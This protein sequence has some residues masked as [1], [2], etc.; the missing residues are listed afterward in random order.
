MLD[1][2]T[3]APRSYVS[4]QDSLRHGRKALSELK[5]V[6][7][8]SEEERKSTAS[9]ITYESLKKRL[10]HRASSSIRHVHSVL[11]GSLSDS[12]RSSL[13]WK[14]SWV[15]GKSLGL[16]IR[17]ENESFVEQQHSKLSKDELELWN[18]IIDESQLLPK[19]DPRT[20]YEFLALRKRP[21]CTS[22]HRTTCKNCGFSV[23]HSQASAGDPAWYTSA[24][25]KIP[26]D[27][28]RNTPLHYSAASGT[29]SLYTFTN[30][31]PHDVD[32]HARNTMNESFLHLLDTGYSGKQG[33]GGSPAYLGLL[34][35]LKSRRFSF[36]D[37]DCHG[38]TILHVLLKR[39][40][41]ADAI[42][43]PHDVR[44][45]L[46]DLLDILE[47]LKPDLNALD[48]QGCNIGDE[49]ITWC[50]RLPST[51][52]LQ[53]HSRVVSL[54]NRYRNPLNANISFRLQI[55]PA[56]WKSEDWLKGLEMANTV[57]WIDIHGDTPLIAILKEWK[58]RNKELELQEMVRRLVGLGVDINMRD[59]CGNT[60][61]A[62][63]AIRGLRAC[64]AELLILGVMPNSRDYRGNSI[65]TV[66]HSRMHQASKAKKNEHYSRILSCVTLLT[67]FGAKKNP[68]QYEEWL[69][70]AFQRLKSL[71]E[72]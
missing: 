55:S 67:D 27:I 41:L 26:T 68:T 69:P 2:S 28:F 32:I 36:S 51:I 40:M 23:L 6:P 56:N 20:A 17:S 71:P 13:S 3:L 15:S 5:P 12:Y 25:D 22:Q 18:D 72:L 52:E 8:R 46:E 70:S 9:V 19:R 66:A 58:Q 45:I 42:I 37:R 10:S 54:V 63:A 48:N 62:I 43:D 16:S 24:G 34:K 53:I 57:T 11:R 31:I 30:L 44:S 50:D 64:V 38:R 59:R 39:S 61:I 1:G 21:C 47:V 7:P 65:I 4:T 29:V 33:I 60:A 35:Y 49:I 14:S